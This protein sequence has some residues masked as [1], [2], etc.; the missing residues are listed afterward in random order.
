MDFR[1]TTQVRITKRL[2]D[3]TYTSGRASHSGASANSEGDVVATGGRWW[4]VWSALLA[5][6]LQLD[7]FQAYTIGGVAMAASARST[8]RSGT[9]PQAGPDPRVGLPPDPGLGPRQHRGRVG[10]PDRPAPGARQRRHLVLQHPGHHRG[11]QLHGHRGGRDDHLPD[12]DPGR[13]AMRPPTT[14]AG[15]SWSRRFLTPVI[16]HGRSHVAVSGGVVYGGW[17]ATVNRAFVASLGSGGPGTSL[18]L[19]ANPARVPV[20]GRF[21]PSRQGDGAERKRHLSP[22]RDHRD[23]TYSRFGILRSALDARK[24]Q[25]RTWHSTWSFRPALLD[26][27]THLPDAAPSWTWKDRPGRYAMDGWEP[28]TDLAIGTR[29]QGDI[30]RWAWSWTCSTLPPTTGSVERGQLSLPGHK[31][32]PSGRP[33][34]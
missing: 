8:P 1:S 21:V 25:G 20:P 13:R 11:Q 12:L 3:G 9:R 2:T 18:R 17:T 15:C 28:A 4:A 30:G 27:P 29:S 7:L 22:L 33:P 23:P 31:I 19:P 32:L 24:E 34:T 14:P 16:E 26:R 6:T 5:R 10:H